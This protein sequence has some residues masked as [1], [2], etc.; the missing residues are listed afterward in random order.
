MLSVNFGGLSCES[1]KAFFRRNAFRSDEFHCHFD[2]KCDV[3]LITRKFCRFCRLEKCFAIGMRKGCLLTDNEKELRQKRIKS[4]KGEFKET[5]DNGIENVVDSTTGTKRSADVAF[6]DNSQSDGN[7]DNS[8]ESSD[9]IDNNDITQDIT[10]YIGLEKTTT[11]MLSIVSIDRP[12]VDNNR[13][14]NELEAKKLSNLLSASA[15]MKRPKGLALESEASG[16]LEV[17]Q[18]FSTKMEEEVQKVIKLSQRLNDFNGIC[19]EDRLQ[20]IKY[21]APEIVFFRLNNGINYGTDFFVITLDNNTSTIVKYELFDSSMDDFNS[22]IR[23]YAQRITHEYDLDPIIQDL[24]NIVI[25]VFCHINAHG[26]TAI[27]LF[28]PNRNNLN[29]RSIIKCQRNVY[30]YLL[31]RYL[32]NKYGSQWVSDQKFVQLMNLLVELRVLCKSYYQRVHECIPH[33]FTP[34]LKEIYDLPQNA[35]TGTCDDTT[36]YYTCFK[37]VLQLGS[38]SQSA[39]SSNSFALASDLVAFGDPLLSAALPLRPSTTL[40]FLWGLGVDSGDA[41]DFDWRFA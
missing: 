35:I 1:C 19:E 24:V 22:S 18:V 41:L 21:G 25:T 4:R 36:A 5:E 33:S 31:R 34:L 38:A 20:L 6:E 3:N 7:T 17:C 39:G 32:Q 30:I 15:V 37:N 2:N 29:H 28:N 11:F 40:V 8:Q 16:L 10:P 26:L 14:F 12:V 23:G 9:T 27:I 13:T